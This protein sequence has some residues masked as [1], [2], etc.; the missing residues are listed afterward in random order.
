MASLNGGAVKHETKLKLQNI[1]ASPNIGT[2][3]EHMFV[4]AGNYPYVC[5]RVKAKRA[6]LLSREAFEKLI[7]ME[8]AQISRTLGEGQYREE[9]NE[10]VHKY[11]GVDLIETATYTNLGRTYA[12]I[13]AFSKDYLKT[14]I[15]EYL[16]RW[17]IYNL[18]T[19]LRG[20]LHDIPEEQIRENLIPAGTFKLEFLQQLIELEHLDNVILALR[21]TWYYNVIVSARATAQQR[22]FPMLMCI[23]NALD[24]AYYEY[25]LTVILPTTKANELFLNFIR[26]EIDVVNLKTMFRLKF[27]AVASQKI[28]EF[29]IDGG[30]ELSLTHLQR[31]AGTNTFQDFVA[32]LKNY[33]IY[34]DIKSAIDKIEH[35]RSLNTVMTELD[36]HL[37]RYADK[38]SY[39]YPL[40]IL[41]VINYMIRKKLEVDNIRI[42]ARGKFRGLAENTI[43]ALLVIL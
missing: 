38:F 23:E 4:S 19:I 17:D 28:H 31:L 5:T 40:S 16:R 11:S 1:A 8:L 21:G 26:K 25:L 2:I 32:M 29:L 42:I 22:K 20:K 10:L 9:I 36:K 15:S 35:T 3:L 14:M 37:L 33:R 18:K 41:P 13:L 24:K 7:L 27:S 30:L 6:L 34:E 43:K 39:V 12:Q